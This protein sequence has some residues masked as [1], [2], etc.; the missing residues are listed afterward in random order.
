MRGGF[1]LLLVLLFESGQSWRVGLLRKAVTASLVAASLGGGAIG[2]IAVHAEDASPSLSAQLKDLQAAKSMEQSKR[3]QEND[4]ELLAKELLMAEGQLIARGTVKVVCD[5]MD[6]SRFPNGFET[7]DAIDPELA[8]GKLFLLAVGREGTLP[9]AARSIPLEGLQFPL[10]WEITWS[11]LLFPYTQ[12]AWLN[13]ANRL[14]S[15]GVTA[16]LTPEQKLAIPNKA[17][18]AGFALSDPVQFAGKITRSTAT[19]QIGAG[20][21][22]DTSLFTPVETQLLT[23]VDDGIARNLSP[24]PKTGSTPSSRR[25]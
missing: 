2:P 23:A 6:V 25:R 17:I 20:E 21:P 8:K 9:L 12:E 22:L 7:A 1:W 18:R 10:V 13:S 14:D 4:Q 19:I 3:L 11:D 5:K 24:A 15:I 16:F